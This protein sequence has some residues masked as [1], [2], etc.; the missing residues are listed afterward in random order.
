MLKIKLL[1]FYINYD[2]SINW[3]EDEY[4]YDKNWN[5]VWSKATN[6]KKTDKKKEEKKKEKP[7]FLG[8][9]PVINGLLNIKNK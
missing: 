8:W 7:V 4:I 1:S 6:S 9:S 2:D 3:V 5:K